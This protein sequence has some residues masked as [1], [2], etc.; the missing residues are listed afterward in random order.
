MKKRRAHSKR[1][2]ETIGGTTRLIR[3]DIKIRDAIKIDISKQNRPK[4][5][6]KPLA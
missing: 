3:V 5:L 6:G 4:L 2:G 1:R